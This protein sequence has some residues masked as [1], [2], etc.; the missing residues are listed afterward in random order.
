MNS[1][2]CTFPIIK[3]TR[4]TETHTYITLLLK[5]V[6]TRAVGNGSFY[7]CFPGETSC[8]LQSPTQ[9]R[10]HSLCYSTSLTTLPCTHMHTHTLFHVIS[11]FW[12][13]V[14]VSLLRSEAHY[15]SFL[16]F[17]SR[18]STC[19]SPSFGRSPSLTWRQ[20]VALA[21]VFPD[22]VSVFLSLSL[23]VALFLSLAL[24]A[25]LIYFAISLYLNS[26]SLCVALFSLFLV[27][28]MVIAEV[29]SLRVK[30][31]RHW[32]E[33]PRPVFP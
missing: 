19:P 13:F 11:H 8:L 24:S 26:T 29:Y 17:P 31:M 5:A 3:G 23:S 25:S 21:C 14:C 9:S 16:N 1:V 32:V 20:C 18:Y 15:K 22:S 30:Q 28:E 6:M 27:S 33:Q 7:G 4:S 2:N 12:V 10:P